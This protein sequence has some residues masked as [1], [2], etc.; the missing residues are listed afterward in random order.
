MEKKGEAKKEFQK[1]VFWHA[2]G[3]LT[4]LWRSHLGPGGSGSEW[5]WQKIIQ[6][7]REGRPETKTDLEFGIVLEAHS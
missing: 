6:Y 3:S 2:Q 4:F 7:L 1:H 5:S